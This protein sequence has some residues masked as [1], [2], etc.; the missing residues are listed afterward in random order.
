MT[1]YSFTQKQGQY[2]AFIY[3]YTK[4]NRMPPAYGDIQYYF[5]VTPPTVNSMLKRLVEMGL[6]SKE[7]GLAR[8]LKVLVPPEKL[9]Y[10]M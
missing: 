10:L 2:L 9:P 3:N 6:L 1:E 8:S 7:Q 5:Q 4:I